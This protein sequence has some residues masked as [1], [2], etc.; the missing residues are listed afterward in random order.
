MRQAGLVGRFERSWTRPC[1]RQILGGPMSQENLEIV[2]RSL[3]HWNETGE[4]LWE[5]L[6]PDVE[7]VI[8]PPAWLAG[9][10]RG[11]AQFKWLN[12]RGAEI[13]D[14]FRYEVD[15]LLP[16]GDLVVSLGRIRVRGTLSG[17]SAVQKGCGVWELRDG[18]IVR[19][20]MYFDREEAL[21]DAGLRE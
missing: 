6:D 9:T 12:S 1:E 13:F 4:P 5:L 17:A 3:D 11:H 15:E 7:Y 19:A 18:R 21:R 16:A 14:E 8:D 10:Y 20:R 2:R